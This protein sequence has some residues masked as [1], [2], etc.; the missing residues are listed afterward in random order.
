MTKWIDDRGASWPL[1]DVVAEICE[2]AGLEP[3]MYEV[4]RLEGDT[5]GFFL[6]QHRDSYEGIEELGIGNFF[7]AASYDGKVNFIPRGD[8]PV[9]TLTSQDVI[10]ESD[11]EDRTREDAI[12]IPYLMQLEYYDIEGGLNADIQQSDRSLDS[13]ATGEKKLQSNEVKDADT[14]KQ[15]IVKAHKVAIE[16]QRGKRTFRLPLTHVGLTVAD[17]IV[18]DG[19][20]MR[21]EEVKMDVDSQ[22]YTAVFD[23]KSAYFSSAKGYPVQIPTE[24]PSAAIGETAIHI[25][26]THILSD[27]DDKLGFYIVAERTTERWE[28]VAIE[29]SRDGGKNYDEQFILNEEGIIG[30]LLEPIKDHPPEYPDTHNQ[31]KLKTMDYRDV[32]MSYDLREMLNR[33]GLMLIGDEL[34]NYGNAEDDAEGN[35]TLSHLFRGRK[36]TPTSSHIDGERVVLFDYGSVPFIESSLYDVGKTFT[37]RITSLGTDVS[38]TMSYTFNGNSQRERKPNRLQVK[39]EGDMMQL[40]WLGT[41]RLGGGRN[42]AMGAYFSGYQVT[43]NGKQHDVVGNQM[44]LTVPYEKGIVSVAQVNSIMGVGESISVRVD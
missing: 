3:H 34:L 11:E 19:E 1:A 25:I 24:P 17:V 4:G 18:L 10:A 28:G 43:I 33:K 23:R 14:A 15:Q 40:S 35:W 5:I 38:Y 13:R 29:V 6:S 44:S 42:V 39:R 32:L 7:D 21:I 30:E 37:L 2:R 26:D 16:E 9:V 22:K 20:R 27:A 31:I 36:G 12:K 41:G 8:N